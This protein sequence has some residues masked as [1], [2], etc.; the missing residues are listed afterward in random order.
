MN[1]DT[2]GWWY[3]QRKISQANPIYTQTKRVRRIQ[4][5]SHVVTKARN[6]RGKAT[7]MRKQVT[8]MGIGLRKV[9]V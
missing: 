3:S 4:K 9:I 5:A 8:T 2:T 7:R 1:D 6:A